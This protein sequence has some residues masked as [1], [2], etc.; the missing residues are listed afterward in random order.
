MASVSRWD[1]NKDLK[2]VSK[3]V[4]VS[5]KSLQLCPTVLTYGL[6]PTRL[7]CPRDFSGKN[8]GGGCHFLLQGIFPTQGLN[9]HLLHWQAGSLPH[10]ATREAQE[11]N[12]EANRKHIS[13]VEA[14]WLSDNT[15]KRDGIIKDYF[16]ATIP[17]KVKVSKMSF[18][19]LFLDRI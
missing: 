7:P 4:M 15:N 10:R 12:R 5:A 3:L 14:T 17:K 8:T 11:E 16:C 18:W 2:E 13:K 1:L 6:Q 9:P 19:N